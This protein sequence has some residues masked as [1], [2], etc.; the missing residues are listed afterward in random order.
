MYNKDNFTFYVRNDIFG[1]KQIYPDTYLYDAAISTKP[2]CTLE[3]LN[4]SIFKVNTYANFKLPIV[5][6]VA[7]SILRDDIIRNDFSKSVSDKSLT[8]IVDMEKDIYYPVWKNGDTY[9]PINCVRFNMHLRTRDMSS[10]KVIEDYVEDESEVNRS[11]W[12]VTDYNFYNKAILH[13]SSPGVTSHTIH[14]ASDLIGYF[15]FTDSEVKNRA[16]KIGKSFLRLSFFS[17]NDPQTQVLLGTSTIFMDESSLC[18][19]Y[20]SM[21][22]SSNIG[23]FINTYFYQNVEINEE[24]VSNDEAFLTDNIGVYNEPYDS[25]GLYDFEENSSKRLSSRIEVYDKHTASNSSEGFYFYMFREYANNMRPLRIYLKID[26]NHAGYGKTIPLMFPRIF[27]KDDDIGVPLY[28][29]FGEWWIFPDGTVFG[30]DN[31]A[32]RYADETGLDYMY[33]TSL[34]YL[35]DGFRLRDIYKQ[36]YIPIDVIF[37]DKNN[38]YVYYLPEQIRENKE[39]GVNNDIM[40]FNLFEVKFKDESVV[41]R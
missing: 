14:N 38:R 9:E 40:E 13:D 21:Q 24:G 41:E 7:N 15:G 2:F 6:G 10:W 3:K 30:I 11:N 37:D 28:L 29:H 34:N 17:T 18:K 36:L 25:D 35:K 23:A 20:I 27:D 22:S 8:N 16:K 33:T 5:N 32:I 31:A 12:F 39:L 19:K 1:E 4:V 26:F